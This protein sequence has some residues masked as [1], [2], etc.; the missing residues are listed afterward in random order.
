M[1]RTVRKIISALAI[2]VIL[3]S[4]SAFAEDSKLVKTSSINEAEPFALSNILQM[5]AGLAFVVVLILLLGWFY[6]RFGTPRTGNSGDFRIVADDVSTGGA[7]SGCY[8]CYHGG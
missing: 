3:F 7:W 4:S 8:F 6:R 5:L 2:M 1:L